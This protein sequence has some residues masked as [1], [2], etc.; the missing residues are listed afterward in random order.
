M[1][2]ICGG[3]GCGGKIGGDENDFNGR[4]IVGLLIVICLW[5][6]WNLNKEKYIG[7]GLNPIGAM[8]S[9]A[10]LRRLAQVFSSPNQGVPATI[11]NADKNGQDIAINVV[12]YPTSSVE[13][14][15]PI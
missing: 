7:S 15:N 5:L 12:M 13:Y 9:G 4:L 3:C 1:S 14:V 10:E 11:Y 2:H 6:L 8:T